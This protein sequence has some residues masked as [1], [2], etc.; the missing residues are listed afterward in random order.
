MEF[1]GK[2]FHRDDLLEA[3]AKDRVYQSDRAFGKIEFGDGTHGAIPPIGRDNIKANYTTGGGKKGN[4]EV[5]K[6]TELK[7]SIPL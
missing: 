7:T 5:S 6:I 3:K 2:W 1:W 4:V